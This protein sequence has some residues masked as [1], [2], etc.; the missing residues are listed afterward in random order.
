VNVAEL[1]TMA[2]LLIPAVLGLWI[3]LWLTKS[4]PSRPLSSRVKLAYAALIS[5]PVI[6]GWRFGGGTDWAS[7]L[8]IYSLVLIL[9]AVIFVLF[10]RRARL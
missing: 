4:V 5:V 9:T 1:I 10:F 8:S 7:P 2:L 6:I 3:G